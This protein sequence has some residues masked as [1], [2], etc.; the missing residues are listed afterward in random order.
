MEEEKREVLEFNKF[1]YAPIVYEYALE[2]RDYWDE[3]LDKPIEDGV[4][5]D[6]EHIDTIFNYADLEKAYESRTAIVKRISDGKFFKGDYT[7]SY[8]YM[9]Y[10]LKL[11][12]VFPKE[13]IV[14]I[15]E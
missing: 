9:D 13:I 7:Y 14:T 4:W 1:D 6:F 8:D 11:V 5:N 2:D 3:D 12:E 10:S 15:Y